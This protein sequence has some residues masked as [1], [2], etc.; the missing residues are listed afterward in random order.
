MFLYIKGFNIFLYLSYS[1]PPSSISSAF[2][3][4]IPNLFYFILLNSIFNSIFHFSPSSLSLLQLVRLSPFFF[5]SH[6]PFISIILSKINFQYIIII[7][8][9]LHLKIFIITTII[10]NSVF[11]IINNLVNTLFLSERTHQVK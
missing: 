1:L 7:I 8:N 11:F 2:S 4:F 9:L 3:L 5:H 6:T 10:L